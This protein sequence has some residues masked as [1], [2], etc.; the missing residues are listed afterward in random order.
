MPI[1]IANRLDCEFLN[2]N[3]RLLPELE[4]AEVQLCP[5]PSGPVERAAEPGRFAMGSGGIPYL[6]QERSGDAAECA[7]QR[8]R[9]RRTQPCQAQSRSTLP[10]TANSSTSGGTV[11]LEVEISDRWPLKAPRAPTGLACSGTGMTQ[12]NLQAVNISATTQRPQQLRWRSSGRMQGQHRSLAI[13][14]SGAIHAADS[15]PANACTKRLFLNMSLQVQFDNVFVD[16]GDGT[17]QASEP[18][19]RQFRLRQRLR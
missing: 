2:L 16:W 10:S 15:A 7:G 13:P 3:W 5:L 1:Q 17:V 18:R 6:Q 14:L 4:L 11:D 9:R 8:R 19:P 12:L